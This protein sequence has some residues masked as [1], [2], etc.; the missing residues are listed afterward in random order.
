MGKYEKDKG[1]AAPAQGRPGNDYD[2]TGGGRH[3]PKPD[4]T[5]GHHGGG[6]SSPSGWGGDRS[7]TD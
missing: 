4:L 7:R 2:A 3:R 6:K 1:D 5:S